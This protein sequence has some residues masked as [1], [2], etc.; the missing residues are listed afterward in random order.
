MPTYPSQVGTINI[1]LDSLLSHPKIISL[2]LL[3]RCIFF[4][5][6]HALVP[7][8]LCS[9]QSCS[10]LSFFTPTSRTFVHPFILPYSTIL[11]TPGF[12][13]RE[14][15]NTERC[16]LLQGQAGWTGRRCRM[17]AIAHSYQRTRCV[18][19]SLCSHPSMG[20]GRQA[21]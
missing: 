13:V 17:A 9:C 8:T 16:S 5:T 3:F 6:L 14:S 20:L 19:R 18:G 15:T 12:Q 7:L 1:H 2:L 4:S 11:A 21:S 10:I